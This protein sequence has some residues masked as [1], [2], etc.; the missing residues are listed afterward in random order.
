VARNPVTG[1]P[2][3]PFDDDGAIG[4]QVADIRTV[5]SVDVV[6]DLGIGEVAVEGDL[7]WDSLSYDPI[8]QFDT[9]IGVALEWRFLTLAIFAL[10]KATELE[11]IVLAAG[12][13]VGGEQIVMGNQVA[14]V[15]MIPEPA[16][17]LDQFAVVVDQRVIDRNH[18]VLAIAGGRVGLQPFQAVCIDA[19]NI[20]SCL[21]QEAVEAGL[22]SRDGEFAI[23]AADGL[24]LGEYEASQ[25][26]GKMAPGRFIRKEVTKLNEQ[27]F[28][29]LWDGNY[30]GHRVLPSQMGIVT[31]VS[32]PTSA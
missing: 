9:Q 26:F 31:D 18:S 28:H 19:L 1:L 22:V 17:I 24:V 27:L 12:M 2:L 5:V 30:C 10:A 20:P 21:S 23:D 25:I 4:F 29:D 15:S 7:T 11:R 8:D 6:D 32:Y 16:G 14:L 3:A 13:D